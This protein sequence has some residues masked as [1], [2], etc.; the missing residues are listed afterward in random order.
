MKRFYVI[1][2]TESVVA[3]DEHRRYQQAERFSPRAGQRDSGRRQ[4]QRGRNDP[5]TQPR[6]MFQEVMVASVMICASHPD[7]NIVPVTFETFSAPDLDEREILKSIFRLVDDLPPES[8]ELVTYGGCWADVPL[9]VIRAM[10]YGLKL[11]K[12]WAPW[13]P[14]GGQGKVPHVDLMRNL[15]GSSKMKASHMAEFAAVLD[16][17]VKMTAEAWRAAEFIR[18][19]RWDRVSLMCE[20]DCI[21]TAL[22]FAS[23]RTTFEDRSA[24]LVVQDRVCRA[25]EELRPGRS[26]LVALRQKR[27]EI[28]AELELEAKRM[29]EIVGLPTAA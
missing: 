3:K 12:A 5:L 14:W 27:R 13:M 16:L 9:I 4:G 25:I 17:P 26:Y 11:P 28:H 22:L 21:T 18:N 6:W 15:T 2:D 24:L 1:I 23:W 20:S 19:R 10:K 8:T 29:N 7:G